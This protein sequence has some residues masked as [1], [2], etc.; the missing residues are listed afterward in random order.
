M[1]DIVDLHP[2]CC[3]CNYSCL[4]ELSAGSL[5]SY[6]C[7]RFNTWMFLKVCYLTLK[8]EYVL[9][10]PLFVS[11]MDPQ[12][13]ERR[14][15]VTPSSSSR[16]HRRRSSGSRDERYRSGEE[17]IHLD[18][19]LVS[20]YLVYQLYVYREQ[21][22]RLGNPLSS[23]MGYIWSLKWYH[24][25]KMLVLPNT[26]KDVIIMLRSCLHIN[27]ETWFLSGPRQWLRQV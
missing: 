27:E 18:P 12:G 14:G 6:S 21:S 24:V 23:I 9:N 3:I 17:Q 11:G 16:Y 2:L 7:R 25:F 19:P 1:C 13:Q 20:L 4:C 5:P 8:E 26:G 22:M 10:L 15:P